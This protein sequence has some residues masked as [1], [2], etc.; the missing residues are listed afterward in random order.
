MGN[1]SE[2]K[3]FCV[4]LGQET[5]GLTTPSSQKPTNT[6]RLMVSSSGK[7]LSTVINCIT[8]PFPSLLSRLQCSSICNREHVPA[9]LNRRPNSFF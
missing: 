9:G 4:H 8:N 1:N 6:R 7:N 2:L 3:F 5:L